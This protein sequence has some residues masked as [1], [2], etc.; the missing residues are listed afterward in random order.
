VL[1]YHHAPLLGKSRL[2]LA[3]TID[4]CQSQDR[5]VEYEKDRSSDLNFRTLDLEASLEKV[6]I[7]AALLREASLLPDH[8]QR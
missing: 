6:A 7:N 4:V 8:S 1:T 3:A 2:I 5:R